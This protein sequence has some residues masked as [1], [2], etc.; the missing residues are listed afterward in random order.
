MAKT[1]RYVPDPRGN[2]SIKKESKTNSPKKMKKTLSI[3]KTVNKVTIPERADV[4]AVKKVSN[5][6]ISSSTM[7]YRNTGSVVAPSNFGSKKIKKTRV[8]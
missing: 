7:T 3:K 4:I 1:A 6:P 8:R 2:S 5:N